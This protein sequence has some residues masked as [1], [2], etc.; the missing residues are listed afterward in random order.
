MTTEEIKKEMDALNTSRQTIEELTRKKVEEYV[1]E[2][3]GSE[4]YVPYFYI[5]SFAV[6]HVDQD[7][8]AFT[9]HIEQLSLSYDDAKFKVSI[10]SKGAF[11][12]GEGCVFEKEYLA[13]ADFIRGASHIK[14]LV[15]DCYIKCNEM[16][17]RY[18]ELE[19]LR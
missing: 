6:C 2:T 11:E 3:C 17:D 4:F 18:R 1:C 7:L 8:N 10:A 19:K 5:G 12:I 13:F 9:V 15:L 14:E 16:R